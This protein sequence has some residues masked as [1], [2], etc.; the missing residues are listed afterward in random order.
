M[1][2]LF[3]AA[4]LAACLTAPLLAQEAAANVSS[5]SS[6]G[7]GQS[8]SNPRPATTEEIPF[9]SFGAGFSYLQTDITDA[10][11]GE[12]TSQIGWYILPEVHITRYLAV[13]GDQ[14]NFQ[15]YHAHAGENVHGFAGGPLYSPFAPYHGITPYV[16][17]EGGSLRVS[18]GGVTNWD[19]AA[20]GGV[21]MNVKITHSLAFQFIPAEYVATKLPNG[22]WESSYTSKAGIVLTNFRKKRHS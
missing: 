21:G 7:G 6:Q 13:I 17:A 8:S 9:I 1:L 22:E 11:G 14:T 20:I 4:M 18:K 5:S 19:P 10:P 2:K 16:F 15:D 12:G 3:S